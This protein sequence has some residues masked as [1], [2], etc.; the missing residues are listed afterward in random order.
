VS[1][2]SHEVLYVIDTPH[3]HKASFVCC[4]AFPKNLASAQGCLVTSRPLETMSKTLLI[5]CSTELL[6]FKFVETYPFLLTLFTSL[7][8]FNELLGEDLFIDNL[9]LCV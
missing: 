9:S 2:T 8:C 3:H 5:A 6:L 1:F 4:S 7:N